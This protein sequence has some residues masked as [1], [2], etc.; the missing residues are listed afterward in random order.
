MRR[1]R[2]MILLAKF[3]CKSPEVI[4]ARD[5]RMDLK[6]HGRRCKHPRCIGLGKGTEEH[7][8]GVCRVGCQKAVLYTVYTVQMLPVQ[9]EKDSTHLGLRI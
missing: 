8:E 5:L 7:E 9:N 6:K 3:R 1:M 4:G 2:R